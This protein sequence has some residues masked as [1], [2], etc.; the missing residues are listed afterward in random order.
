MTAWKKKYPWKGCSR[1]NIE[2]DELGNYLSFD[3]HTFSSINIQFLLAIIVVGGSFRWPDKWREARGRARRGGRDRRGGWTFFSRWGMS[4]IIFCGCPEIISPGPLCV[5]ALGVAALPLSSLFYT[6]S[7]NVLN[8][9]PLDSPPLPPLHRPS[10]PPGRRMAWEPP[11]KSSDAKC[12]WRY[13]L[14]SPLLCIMRNFPS[15]LLL[16]PCSSRKVAQVLVCTAR[17]Y[18]S[19]EQKSLGRKL[20]TFKHSWERRVSWKKADWLEQ[21][22]LYNYTLR[23]RIIYFER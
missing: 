9:L 2:K 12:V 1:N 22:Q 11:A 17:G 4:G 20:I 18:H 14:V 23:I 6:L 10:F 19:Y 13:P 21:F 5:V 7:E 3:H 15:P 8:P 16:L